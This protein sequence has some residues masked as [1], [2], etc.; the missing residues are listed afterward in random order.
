M[1]N[2][3][4]ILLDWIRRELLRSKDYNDEKQEDPECISRDYPSIAY[5]A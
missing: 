1:K 5:R 2:P 4:M 3:G